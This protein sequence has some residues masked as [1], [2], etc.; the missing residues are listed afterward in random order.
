M[1][2]VISMIIINSINTKCSSYTYNKHSTILIIVMIISKILLFSKS[3]KL[4]FVIS[5]KT[6]KDTS[7][8]L[9][10]VR[11]FEVCSNA[12]KFVSYSK[13]HHL[14]YQLKTTYQL[15]TTNYQLPTTY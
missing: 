6:L 15:P 14:N 1:Q 11:L 13:S 5:K 12:L 9:R 10:F 4:F 2:K 7:Y 3:K 8:A